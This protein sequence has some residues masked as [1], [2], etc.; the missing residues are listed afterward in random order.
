MRYGQL[1]ADDYGPGD[2]QPP[3][4]LLHGLTFDRRQWTPVLQ[5]PPVA[6]SGRRI[7]TFDLPGHG[8]SP[9]RDSYRSAEIT[10]ALHDA[11]KDAGAHNPVIAGHSIGGVLAT[12]Y[13]SRHPVSGIVNIDQPLLAGG[14]ADFLHK[15]EPAL[16]S[17]SYRQTWE[18]LL[19]GMGTEEL[20]APAAQLVHVT[21]APRQDLLLGYWDELLTEPADQ[22][23]EAR[24]HD[25]AAIRTAG[26]P[27]HY[28]ASHEVPAPYQSW[29][30]TALPDIDITV[31]PG[32]T[33][34]AHLTHPAEIADILLR[35]GTPR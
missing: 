29:L 16:R 26:T 4:V 5:Q 30:T 25:L 31:I 6:A 9:R 18:T 11:I 23:K 21:S 24:E 28:I 10:E 13:A 1:A 8:Q 3:L 15:S 2:R 34:F 19:A 12:T 20:P 32:A 14:F 22:L 33:H 17:D 27:Y 7:I 35:T